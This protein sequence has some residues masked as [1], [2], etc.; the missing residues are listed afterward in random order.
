MPAHRDRDIPSTHT[1]RHTHT[2]AAH[3][4]TRP[5]MLQSVERRGNILRKHQKFLTAQKSATSEAQF[6]FF[7]NTLHG[8]GK[9]AI[10]WQFGC[11]FTWLIFFIYGDSYEI[12]ISFNFEPYIF[13]LFCLSIYTSIHPSLHLSVFL[14]VYLS[15]ILSIFP[16][17]RTFVCHFVGLSIYPSVSPSDY[18]FVCLSLYRSLCMN[19]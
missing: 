19:A 17:R 8:M 3:T 11:S 1:C 16:D 15:I 10:S 13:L 2:H 14:S 7:L 18:P 6:S 4:H 12:F 5:F 9:G